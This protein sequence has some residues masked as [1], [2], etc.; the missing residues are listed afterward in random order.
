[1]FITY[2]KIR[3]FH[4]LVQPENGTIL[5]SSRFVR[6]FTWVLTYII[7]KPLRIKPNLVS[8]LGIFTGLIASLFALR[9]EY[10]LFSYCV[11]LWTIFDCVDGELA[12]LTKNFSSRGLILEKI[13]SDLQYSL[14]IPTLGIGLFNQGFI[15]LFELFAAL[16]STAIFV[17]LRSFLNKKPVGIKNIHKDL[18]R[19]IGSQFKDGNVY[20]SHSLVGKTLYIFWRNGTTQFGL[21]PIYCVLILFYGEIVV[22]L[23]LSQYTAMYFLVSIGIILGLFLIKKLNLV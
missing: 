8:I 22:K 7:F 18:R 15:T 16:V 21:F 19:I 5:I 4:R 17:A 1:M 10:N 3:K 11:L 9:S 12:R 13:N 23:M 14:W 2:E 20:R 6:V